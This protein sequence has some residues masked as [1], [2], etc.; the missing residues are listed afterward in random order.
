M[1]EERNEP[2]LLGVIAAVCMSSRQSSLRPLRW[3]HDQGKNTHREEIDRR[4]EG[5]FLMGQCPRH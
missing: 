5:T 1:R 2:L 3:L 4:R